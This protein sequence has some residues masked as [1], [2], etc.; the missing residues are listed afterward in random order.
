MISRID[1]LLLGGLLLAWIG[2]S[3]ADVVYLK[4]GT[5]LH[6]RVM[7]ERDKLVDRATGLALPVPKGNNVYTVWDGTR[8]VFFSPIQL[9]VA[10]PPTQDDR[11]ADLLQLQR[12]ISARPLLKLPGGR[13]QGTLQF[14]EKGKRRVKLLLD[15]TGRRFIDVEQ[16]L[17]FLS[18]YQMRVY[19]IDYAWAQNYLTTE[20]DRNLVKSWAVQ[21]PQIKDE[22]DPIEKRFKFYRFLVECRW[23]DDA[24]RE[25]DDIEQNLPDAHERVR[26]SREALRQLVAASQ[27]DDAQRAWEVGQLE[28]CRQL[29]QQLPKEGLEAD[30]SLRINALRVKV[31][32]LSRRLELARRYLR[33]LP[34][35]VEGPFAELLCDAASAIRDELHVDGLERLEPFLNLAEQAERAVKAGRDPVDRPDQLLARAVSGWLL[36]KEAADGRPEVAQRLWRAREMAATYIRTPLSRDRQLLLE[37]YEKGPTVEIEELARIIALLPPAEVEPFSFEGLGPSPQPQERRTQLPGVSRSPVT[38]WVQLPPEYRPGR[39]YPLLVL[40]HDDDERPQRILE[41]FRAEAMRRGYV[42]VAPEWGAGFGGGYRYEEEDRQKILDVLRDAKLRFHIDDDRIFLAGQGGGGEAAWDVGLSHPDLFA[43]VVPIGANPRKDLLIRYW[44]NA[45]HL[46]FYLVAG[47]YGGD[48]APHLMRVMENWINRGFPC[49]SVIYAGRGRDSFLGELPFIFDWLGR[50]RRIFPFPELGRWPTGEW[51]AL[52]TA[53]PS[54]SHFYWLTADEFRPGYIESDRGIPRY[55]AQLQAIVRPG[56]LID[57]HGV[58]LKQVSVWLTPNMVDL[59]KPLTI[60]RTHNFALNP[61]KIDQ[62]KPDLSLMMET[63]LEHGDH[64]RLFIA[65]ISLAP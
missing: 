51:T 34:D 14:D 55:P 59:S 16:V 57:V 60:R 31:E 24:A 40:L 39:P 4:D 18:P 48:S 62:I 65:R 64:A 32:S 35:G 2:S 28:T 9:D 42:V 5:V 41:R 30:L 56:N 33:T 6:G 47:E 22:K 45:I 13:V 44:P 46:P 54:S 11:F 29:L 20:I 38:Y 3:R 58:G 63:F 19:S 21:F 53:R 15:D 8:L 49:L 23:Y 52:V 27:L 26:S 1:L 10:R 17:S 7:M 25:L 37:R 12:S 61:V 50:R 43:A 36:G